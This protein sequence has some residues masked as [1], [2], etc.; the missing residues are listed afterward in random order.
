MERPKVLVVDDDA[1]L[2]QSLSLRLRHEGYD[3]AVAMNGYQGL[4]R[5]RTES[6]DLL[7][8]DINMPA[9][10]GFS[11]QDRLQKMMGP[12]PIVIYLTADRSLRADLMSKKLGAFAVIHKPFDIARLLETVRRAVA[13]SRD[14][15]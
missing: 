14:A 15:V 11:V 12:W 4:E 3:V 6:P 7:I 13:V 1:D 5:A 8:L 9:G 2:V 10:N